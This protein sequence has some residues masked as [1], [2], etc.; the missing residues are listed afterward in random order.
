[1]DVAGDDEVG[2]ENGCRGLRW[3]VEAEENG[4]NAIREDT[5]SRG[6]S[7]LSASYAE[8]QS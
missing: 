4:V 6:L 3:V 7:V 1:M 8:L 5:E 2:L